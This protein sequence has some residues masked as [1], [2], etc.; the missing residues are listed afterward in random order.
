MN[1]QRIRRLHVRFFCSD[2]LP[3]QGFHSLFYVGQFKK[4]T[5]TQGDDFLRIL[6]QAGIRESLGLGLFPDTP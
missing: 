4:Q 6:R 5:L 2:L 1:S 3:A